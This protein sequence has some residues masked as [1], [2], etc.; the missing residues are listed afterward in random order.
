MCVG[1]GLGMVWLDGWVLVLGHRV[2]GVVGFLNSPLTSWVI[3]QTHVS[4]RPS[5]CVCWVWFGHGWLD[6]WVF[7][8]VLGFCLVGG[9]PGVWP[10]KNVL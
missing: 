6:G 7:I 3:F 4:M 2:C 8:R 1:Y 9:G 10:R 5:V